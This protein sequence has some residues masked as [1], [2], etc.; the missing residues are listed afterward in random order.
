MR[1]FVAAAAAMLVSAAAVTAVA[2]EPIDLTGRSM[3]VVDASGATH[4]I[5]YDA[6]NVVR[7][8]AGDQTA[9]GRWEVA[10]GQLCFEFPGEARDCWP[11]DGDFPTGQAVPV[12]SPKGD[13]Y[14]ITLN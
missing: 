5:H 10:D 3:T 13:A 2:Q 12:T 11:W 14:I 7:A 4:T 1:T 9:T 6:E 8:V